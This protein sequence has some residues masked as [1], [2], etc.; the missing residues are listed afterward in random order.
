[1]QK[2]GI[3]NSIWTSIE[4]IYSRQLEIWRWNS[5][6]RWNLESLILLLPV[7]GMGVHRESRKWE[8]LQYDFLRKPRFECQVLLLTSS[9]ILALYFSQTESTTVT[10]LITY[11]NDPVKCECVLE[12]LWKTFYTFDHKIFPTAPTDWDIHCSTSLKNWKWPK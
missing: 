12:K 6:D 1:M 10:F 8:H 7:K 11:L 4:K 3:S 9:E 5:R 2:D